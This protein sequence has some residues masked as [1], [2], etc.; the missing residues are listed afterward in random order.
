M[1]HFGQ[2]RLMRNRLVVVSL[3]VI[4]GCTDDRLEEADP[5]FGAAPASTITSAQVSDWNAAHAWGDHRAAGYLTS[6]TAKAET[7]PQVGPLSP[8]QYCVGSAS[9]TEIQCDAPPPND[10]RCDSAGV[11][12]TAVRVEKVIYTAPRTHLLVLGDADFRGRNADSRVE[13]CAAVRAGASITNGTSDGLVAP[14]PL[15][16][17]AVIKRA[18]FHFEDRNPTVNLRLSIAT[19][20]LT[21]GTAAAGTPV[22]TAGEPGV[23]SVV[24]VLDPPYTVKSTHAVQVVA[25]PDDKGVVAWPDAAAP[26]RVRGAVIEY[27][28]SEAP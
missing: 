13:C 2:H 22:F 12:C 3:A 10:T 6:E 23:S 8:G 17:G 9:G 28:L 14:I 19:Q 4:L 24:Q 5:V 26:L 16:V 15:P 25:L 1:R 18:T 11:S 21:G 20:S 27:E 7:D